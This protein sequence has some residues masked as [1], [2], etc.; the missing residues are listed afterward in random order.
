[1]LSVYDGFEGMSA[2]VQRGL[3]LQHPDEGVYVCSLYA[4][5]L[6]LTR[7]RDVANLQPLSLVALYSR[8]E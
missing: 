4:H 1:M 6:R 7:R 2:G 3:L 8:F 5:A